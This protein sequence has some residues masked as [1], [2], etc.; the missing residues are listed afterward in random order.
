MKRRHS[1]GPIEQVSLFRRAKRAWWGVEAT[2][3][4]PCG[5]GGELRRKRS[6]IITRRCFFGKEAGRPHWQG[7]WVVPGHRGRRVSLGSRSHAH[8]PLAWHWSPTGGQP[9]SFQPHAH[10]A[11]SHHHT[12]I[13]LAWLASPLAGSLLPS[14]IVNFAL[15][16]SYGHHAA[17]WRAAADHFRLYSERLTSC[18][19]RRRSTHSH[20]PTLN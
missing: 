11:S 14:S 1:G 20:T 15:F 7:F 10:Q 3:I 13:S 18:W 16:I 2:W 12:I 9:G 17:V 19:C 5:D 6:R 4:R 8:A